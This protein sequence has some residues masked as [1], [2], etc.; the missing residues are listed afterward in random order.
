MTTTAYLHIGAGKTGTSAIQATLAASRNLLLRHGIC[1][2]N[3]T[4]KSDSDSLQGRVSSGNGLTLARLLNPRLPRPKTW[5]REK[6]LKWLDEI[7]EKSI[8]QECKILISNEH[9]QFAKAEKIA[10]I[11]EHFTKHGVNLEVIFYVRTAIDYSISE[12][13]QKL[14]VGQV[15]SPSD[16]S[17]DKY[18]QSAK[19]PFVS[20]LR[21][22]EKSGCISQFHIRSYDKRKTMLIKDFFNELNVSHDPVQSLAGNRIINRSLTSAER[23]AFESLLSLPN[24]SRICRAIGIEVA[25]TAASDE[26]KRPHYISKE[27]FEQYCLHNSPL[28]ETINEAFRDKRESLEIWTE[29]SDFTTYKDE[30]N[31][32]ADVIHR[33]YARLLS[34]LPALQAI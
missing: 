25:H 2:P 27:S 19:V 23:E 32:P 34:T 28:V 4:T 11:A 31:Y 5:Q 20:T 29:S 33:T 6:A 22:F 26:S 15:P 8:Q 30:S 13:L 17:L 10:N 18:L 21:Q 16:L 24:G 7:I 9:M 1:Y 12:Y 3:D 14:K